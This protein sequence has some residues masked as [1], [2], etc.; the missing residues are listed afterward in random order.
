MDLVITE[1]RKFLKITKCT[2]REYDQMVLSLTKKIDGWRFNP[3]VKRGLWNGEISF[4][5]KGYIPSGLWHE[6]QDIGKNFNFEAKVLNLDVL[7]D[8]E[9]SPE[10]FTMW[11]EEFFED[12]EKKPRD[13]QIDTAIKILKYKTC[14]AELATSAGKTMIIFMVLGYLLHKEKVVKILMIVPNVSLVMQSTEDFD[15]YNNEKLNLRI[16]QVYGGSKIKLKT[17]LVIGTFQ[18]LAKLE[19]EYFDQFQVVVTDETHRATSASIRKILDK[20][21]HCTYR[22]GVSGT[23]PKS[24]TIDRLNIMSNT[25]P[26]ITSVNASDLIDKGHITPCRVSIIQMSYAEEEQ[27]EAFYSLS[28]T[29]EDRKS[30]F[31]LEQKFI[32]NNKKRLDFITKFI[33]KVTK[34]SMVLFHRIEYGEAIYNILRNLVDNEVYYVSGVT[35]KDD[36]EDY[37]KTM[38]DGEGKILVASFGTFSTGVSINNIHN[39]FL[40][41]SFKSD[42]IIRQSIGRGLR[43]HDD[44]EVLNIVDFV[45]DI[46]YE[47]EYGK[48]WN[49]YLYKHA[50]RRQEIYKEQNFPYVIKKVSF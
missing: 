10:D 45:D 26:L 27:R 6:V 16:Q 40:V 48:R 35:G 3:L 38:E 25:G 37:K 28:K 46:R 21:W 32:V 1:D 24:G 43:K 36:R 42:V 11:V 34:N 19:Q 5:K 50:I 7:F 31:A 9:F 41:E 12:A 29:S 15:T 49:N 14:L 33:S 2:E 44:K 4:I 17:N 13:Y 22:F 20:C 30:L 8:K 23:I 39:I 18:S 47:D